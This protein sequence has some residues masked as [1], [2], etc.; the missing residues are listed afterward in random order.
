MKRFRL[1]SL[2]AWMGYS[3]VGCQEDIA[4]LDLIQATPVNAV[5]LIPVRHAPT[6]LSAWT[7][8][9][10]LPDADKLEFFMKQLPLDANREGLL[11]LH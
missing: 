3:L 4:N 8:G 9:Q 2:A 6:L 5:V 1:L 11:S 10:A 7:D